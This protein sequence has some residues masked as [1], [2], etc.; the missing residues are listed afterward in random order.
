MNKRH[1]SEMKEWI[2]ECKAGDSLLLS[3]VVYAARD[4]I[5][6]KWMAS[7]LRGETFP[8]S[9]ER[10]GIYYVGPT[11]AMPGHVIGSCGPTTSARMDMYYPTLADLG[12]RLTIGKGNRSEE[13]RQKIV[14]T[15]GIY[16]CAIGGA[17]AFYAN[18][19]K[20]MEI[21]AFEEL[22][23]ESLK[24]LELMDMPVYVGIDCYGNQIF[25]AG[26]G[27]ELT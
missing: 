3:G 7:I 9:F 16:L 15:G 24:K 14:Q 1:I 26:N 21:V 17:G 4:A 27:G 18:C 8:L 19:V 2:P 13:V 10:A 23:C 22:G 6:K 25:S 12:L 20:S 5:H 11:P